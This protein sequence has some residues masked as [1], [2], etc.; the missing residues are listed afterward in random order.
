MN[1][2][3]VRFFVVLAMGLAAITG[4]LA[5]GADKDAPAASPPLS[6][7]DAQQIRKII[8]TQ[9]AA[10]AQDDADGAFATATPSVRQAVGDS[11]RFLAMVRGA[12]PMVYHP[13]VVKFQKPEVDEDDGGVIQLVEVVDGNRQ[14][15]IA[16]FALE[17]QP[18]ASWRISGCAVA[19]NRWLAT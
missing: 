11:T 16:L 12:Y 15:W 13:S 17:R 6:D 3:V 18:D 14:S 5:W 10:F 1:A 2:I 4:P 19:E 7:Q 8:A 9:L